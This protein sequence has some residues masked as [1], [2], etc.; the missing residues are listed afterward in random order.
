MKTPF[1]PTRIP[2]TVSSDVPTVPF[3]SSGQ[4]TRKKRVLVANRENR[5][6]PMPSSPLPSIGSLGMGSTSSLRGA[7]RNKRK[8]LICS[9]FK[10]HLPSRRLFGSS[11]RTDTLSNAFDSVCILSRTEACLQN[12][13]VL[14]ACI[15]EKKWCN[16]PDYYATCLSRLF[17][18]I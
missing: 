13:A 7:S 9:R 5:V 6:V 2:G 11:F 17:S 4:R 15:W 1:S 16:L 12:N 10:Y 18:H 3:A 14:H 8:F